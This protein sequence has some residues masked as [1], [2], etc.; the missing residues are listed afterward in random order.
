[1]YY[2]IFQYLYYFTFCHEDCP[3][4]F[5]IV[6]N[7]PRK[8]LPCQPTSEFPEP[9]TFEEAGL[10]KN[11]MLFVQDNESWLIMNVCDTWTRNN[12]YMIEN[13]GKV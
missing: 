8:T 3:D 13:T 4:D 11:E 6:T 5:H 12:F 1:M 10:G 9:I 2:F 7:F